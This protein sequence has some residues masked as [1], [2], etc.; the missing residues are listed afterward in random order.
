MVP[1]NLGLFYLTHARGSVKLNMS[2]GDLANQL[3]FYRST[4]D[5]FDRRAD[6]SSCYVPIHATE[7]LIYR[8]NSFA[9]AQ[10]RSELGKLTC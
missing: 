9:I 1:Q 6:D 7:V 8:V 3:D 5:E 4:P 10:S 2:V